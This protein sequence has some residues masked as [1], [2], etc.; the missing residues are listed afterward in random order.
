MKIA[1]IPAR[2]GSKRIPRK[3]VKPF[4]GKPMIA[5]AIGVAQRSGLFDHIVVSTDDAEIA[6]VAGEFGAEVPFVRPAALAD[7]L[8]PTVPVIAHAISACQALGWPVNQV[9]SIYP[10]V[11]FLQEDDLVSAL[12]MLETCDA[13]YVFPI[14]PFPSAIQRAL[15]QLPDGEI[16]P[17]YSEH[18]TVRTQ[19]LE[20]AFYDAGQFYWGIA[21]TWLEGKII[22]K[23]AV[24]LIIPD[25]RVVDIDTHED[26]Q[27][28]ELIYAVFKD[29]NC[30]KP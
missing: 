5:H 8:T 2:G 7:D 22:H 10:A 30:P 18:A 17:F 16:E 21:Q 4:A 29:G 6:R 13:G 27:R 14:T 1:V 25:W 26:W 15:R 23:H 12:R 28:A 3:N 19:D 9:C 20:P 11:P 24:G